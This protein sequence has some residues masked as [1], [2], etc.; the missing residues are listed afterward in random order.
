[1]SYGRVLY[2]YYRTYDPSTGRYLESDPVGLVGGLNTY[3]YAKQNPLSWYDIFGLDPYLVSRP[4]S[5]TSK[6]SHNFV[7]TD[8]AYLGDPNAD[9]FS[10]G[11]NNDGKTGR[12]DE[13]TRG[14][15]EGTSEADQEFWRDLASDSSCNTSNENVSRIPASDE[16]VRELAES[17]RP[18]TV[19]SPLPLLWETNSNSAASA[20]AN[21]AAESVVPINSDG[22]LSPGA[23]RAKNI[24]FG[25][26]G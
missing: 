3:E 26:E 23:G 4:L 9:V 1:M 13:S 16:V 11:K 12:V 6:A 8:A 22:R 7:V 18:N 14:F 10:Y 17:L 25:D 19:Y 5:F 15:S 21:Q 2:N 20:I 24:K